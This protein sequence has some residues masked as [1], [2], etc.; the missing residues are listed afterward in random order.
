MSPEE[1]RSLL[2]RRPFMPFRIH[3]SDEASYE[4]RKPDMVSIGRTI[5]FLGLVR[6]VQS[7]FFDEPVLIA[8]RHITRIEPI[9]EAIPA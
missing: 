6:D 2:Q 4:V 7:E 5:L 8:L 9:V 3:V 1:L